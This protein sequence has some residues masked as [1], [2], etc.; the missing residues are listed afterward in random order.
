M[1]ETEQYFSFPSKLKPYL[2]S[3]SNDFEFRHR[4]VYYHIEKVTLAMKC[5]S[6]KTE[7]LSFPQNQHVEARFQQS[8]I[9][10]KGT[11]IINYV[12]SNKPEILICTIISWPELP[13][14]IK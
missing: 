1:F 2:T 8:P 5:L 3:L 13:L 12:S 14:K 9:Y 7:F 6:E 10:R 11:Q 4:F